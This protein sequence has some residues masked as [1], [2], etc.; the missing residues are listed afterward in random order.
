MRT[1]SSVNWISS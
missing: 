1:L